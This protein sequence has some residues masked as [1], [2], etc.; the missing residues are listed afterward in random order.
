M[1]FGDYRDFAAFVPVVGL[2]PQEACGFRW[3]DEDILRFL[4]KVVA[5]PHPTDPNRVCLIFTGAKSRGRGN[6]AWYG[7]FYVKGKV[8][9]AHKFA[10][11]AIM[12]Q[13]PKK[14]VNHLDHTCGN[15]RCVSCIETVTILVNLKR[16][17]GKEHASG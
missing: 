14:G 9:R 10:A 7:S 4:T 3:T 8:I 11:V 13:R 1:Y 12:G 2:P 16:R 17:W 5:Q 6:T 15:S